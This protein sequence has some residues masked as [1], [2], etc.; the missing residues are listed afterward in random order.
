M[1][2]LFFKLVK[3]VWGY[4]VKIHFDCGISL[5]DAV[6]L[7][8]KILWEPCCRCAHLPLFRS[9]FIDIFACIGCHT[10]LTI[11][12]RRSA[13]ASQKPVYFRGTKWFRWYACATLFLYFCTG[14]LWLLLKLFN[15]KQ[16]LSDSSKEE[17]RE[18]GKN[19]LLKLNIIRQKEH[20][21]A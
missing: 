9:M 5:R 16:K 14:F 20:F 21:S 12:Y 11:G 15:L 7:K 1:I 3:T 4:Q 2:I 6:R 13:D 10:H 18:R 19:S 8:E 17:F